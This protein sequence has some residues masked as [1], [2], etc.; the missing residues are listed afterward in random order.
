[1]KIR[2]VEF[3]GTVMN[4]KAPFPGTLPQVAFAGRSNV[5]KSSLI[6]VLLGRT[7]KKLAHV[8]ATPGKT[9]GLNFYRVN[10]TFFLVDLPGF[11]FARAPRPVR[12]A[13]KK[14]VEGY[15]ARPDGPRA[16]VHLIDI[17]RDPT[18]DDL[19]MLDFLARAGLPSVIVLTKLDKLSKEKGKRQVTELTRT[20]RL[21]PDQVIPFSSKTGEGKELLLD[22]VSALVG[23]VADEGGGERAGDEVAAGEVEVDDAAFDDVP[24]GNPGVAGGEDVDGEGR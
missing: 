15:L 11:G 1:M 2:Q 17:R 16:V 5:G 14:L 12:D 4:P 10:E 6:N 19:Q 24:V 3:A 23:E 13:W 8:S 9:Q 7:R 18:P 21:D 22:A 20:M